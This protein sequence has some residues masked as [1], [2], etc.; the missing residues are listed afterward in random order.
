V[1]A[2]Q[3]PAPPPN[4]YLAGFM[5][6]GKSL[7][8]RRLAEMK[9]MRF[10]DSDEVIARGAGK[11]VAQIFTEDG[12]A[13]FRRKEREFVEHGHP[14]RGCVVSLGGGMVT[15]P[16][17]IEL[18]RSKG[19]LVCLIASAETIM[20]RTKNNPSRPLLNVPDPEA[21][22][23]ELLA[24]RDEFYRRAGTNIATDG[25][26]LGDLLEHLDRIYRREARNF[27]GK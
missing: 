16:G 19:V 23:R 25:R 3:P 10:L 6:T 15:Q 27:E 17:I 22:V 26:S 9:G 18:L 2:K 5:G 4:L 7:L 1:P 12:E 13:E 8:G 14:E 21:R 11:P 24:E 20:Q